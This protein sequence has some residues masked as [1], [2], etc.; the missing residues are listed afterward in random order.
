[1]MAGVQLE[2]ISHT[3]PMAFTVTRSINPN[4]TFAERLHH[5]WFADRTENRQESRNRLE[6]LNKLNN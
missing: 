5:S 2:V 4:L 6:W 1:M 3:D